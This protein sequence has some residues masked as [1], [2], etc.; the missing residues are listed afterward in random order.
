MK[1][2]KFIAAIAV[3]LL[4]SLLVA[5]MGALAA[6]EWIE[7][8]GGH[9]GPRMRAYA[10][11]WDR[12]EGYP[13]NAVD[14][15][16]GSLWH[17]LWNLGAALDYHVPELA[18]DLEENHQGNF[19]K[20]WIVEFEDTFTLNRIGYLPRADAF[21]G[22][23]TWG[24]WWV[25][26]T[27]SIEDFDSRDGWTMVGEIDMRGEGFAEALAQEEP[28]EP[29]NLWD[30]MARFVYADFDEIEARF[31]KLVVHH[32]VGGWASA[33]EIGFGFTNVPYIPFAGFTP[34]ESFQPRTPPMWMAPEMIIRGSRTIIRATDFDPDHY[35]KEGTDGNQDIRAGHAVRTEVGESQFGSNIGW[36]GPGDW[37]QY[38]VQVA[39]DGNFLFSAW[40]ASDADAPGGVRVYVDGE[41]VGQS[42][43]TTRSAWQD[44]NLYEVGN[45][46]LEAGQRVIRVEFP[47][48]GLN[49]AALEVTP[50]VEAIPEP[51]PTEAPAEEPPADG[52]NGEDA[53]NGAEAAPPA[54]TPAVDDDGNVV[55]IVIIIIAVVVVVVIVVVVVTKKKS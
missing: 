21:N 45:I 10:N 24:E 34:E 22:T 15:Y 23:V 27:G 55:V 32:G 49:F 18:L 14:R 48:G 46:A 8:V 20:I 47:D 36:I 51:D 17:S 42:E 33:A 26:T 4:L 31:V 39:A 9:E 37:V 44:Y 1:A 11:T 28:E 50:Y 43:A 29:E 40:Q 19:P 2:R 52:A 25:S 13:N 7:W 3:V 6:P 12:S 30:G 54:A 16:Q 35:G 5:P 41:L 38:T 53:E